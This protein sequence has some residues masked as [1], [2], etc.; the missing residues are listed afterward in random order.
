[1]VGSDYGL[2]FPQV[3]DTMLHFQSNGLSIHW[4]TP[5]FGGGLPAY[6]NPNNVQFSIPQ[7]LVMLFPPWQAVLIT[8]IIH[9]S[10]G[11]FACFYLLCRVLKM[12]WTSSILGAIFFTA[13]GFILE[14]FAVGHLNFAIGLLLLPLIMIAFLDPSIPWSAAGFIF[15]L[16]VTMLIHEAGYFILVIFALSSLITLPLIYILQPAIFSG[17]H[18][19]SIIAFGGITSLLMSASKLAA[20]YSFMRFFPREL[21]DHYS[22]G[23]RSGL[24][25][26]ALQLLGTMNLVPVWRLVGANPNGLLDY[27]RIMTRSQWG[28]WELDMSMS[29]VIF[30]ILAGGGLAFFISPKRHLRSLGSGYK[31]VA[32]ILFFLSTW[33]AIEFSVAKGWIYP[34]V[35]DLPILSSLHVN[36]R[37]AAAF[38][39]PLAFSAACIYDAF[40]QKIQRRNSLLLFLVVNILTLLPLSTFFMFDKDLQNRIYD[41]TDSIAIYDAIRSGDP[42]T[43]T[44]IRAE[45]NNTQALSSRTSNLHPYEPIFGYELEDFHPEVKPGSI[46]D[47]SDGYYNMTNPSGYVYPEINGSRPFERIR[48]ED[49]E[50]LER[51]SRHRQPNW[52]LPLYQ[53]VLNWVSG[54]TFVAA[55]LMLGI[56]GIDQ[57]RTLLLMER[58]KR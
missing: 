10:M 25:G 17:K 16:V 51:F 33:L 42:F 41:T 56:Y 54:A 31:W 9:L 50:K 19:F 58:E 23:F 49:R 27:L 14:R 3:L 47:I 20:V 32:W 29:P 8:S 45:G 40:T 34:H 24:S 22:G 11:F 30:A 38:I 57:A 2:M 4:Y 48:V 43:I 15:A 37:Y 26:L 46:W 52:K 44:A 5:T 21:A 39:F 55:S 35:R 28:Y 1:M 18:L 36:M 13:N 53:Q 6:P 12:H 7:M